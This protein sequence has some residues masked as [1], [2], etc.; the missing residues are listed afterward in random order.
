M[1]GKARG[2]EE[3]VVTCTD[4]IYKRFSEE[5]MQWNILELVGD[6]E[7]ILSV[8]FNNHNNAMIP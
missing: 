7:T 3:E 2:K 5:V 8:R 4:P 6:V 1:T